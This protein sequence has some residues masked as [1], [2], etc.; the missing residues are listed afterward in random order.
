[1]YDAFAFIFR[2]IPANK[3]NYYIINPDGNLPQTEARLKP[4]F[5]ARLPGWQGLIGEKPSEQQMID[6]LSSSNTYM[7]V[8][9]INMHYIDSII[10]RVH[11][12]RV[13]FFIDPNS[14]YLF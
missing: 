11:V 4:F 8:C 1:M 6:V 10:T 14:S 13:F 12:S 3:I 2:E 7:Y 9:S 5:Q